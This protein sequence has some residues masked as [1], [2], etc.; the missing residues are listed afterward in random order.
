V[1]PVG[2]IKE[3]V[4]AAYRAG[5][6]MVILPS[7][8]LKDLDDISS[9]I[10]ER[11]QFVPIL[12]MDEA[13]PLVLAPPRVTR[14]A[15]DTGTGP[16]GFPSPQPARTTASPQTEL[17]GGRVARARVRRVEVVAGS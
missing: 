16:A 11:L 10:R 13:L 2:G 12:H 15:D 14:P 6:R 8:N 9:D 7:R 5:V 1:L 4:L 3:K 17:V